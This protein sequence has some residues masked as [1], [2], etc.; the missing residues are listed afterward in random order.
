MGIETDWF[1]IIF[2]LKVFPLLSKVSGFIGSWNQLKGTVSDKQKADVA[3]RSLTS[4]DR[5][6]SDEGNDAALPLDTLQ[7]HSVKQFVQVSR[8]MVSRFRVVN[9][10]NQLD[11]METR[12]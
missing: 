9:D 7:L 8:D 5:R 12:R 10:F 3:D 2:D 6:E 4:P 11:W 1:K